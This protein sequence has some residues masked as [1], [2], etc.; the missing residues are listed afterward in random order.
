MYLFNQITIGKYYKLVKFNYGIRMSDINNGIINNNNIK[1]TKILGK[2]VDKVTYGRP[3]D[4]DVTFHFQGTDGKILKYDP[5]FG[6]TE[7]YIEYENDT[8]EKSKQRIHE[9]TAELKLEIIGNDWAL[10]PENVVA[11]QCIDIHTYNTI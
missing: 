11:T 9:R 7:A 1:E 4:L 3:Y 8:E 10:R 2:L 5:T 6:M